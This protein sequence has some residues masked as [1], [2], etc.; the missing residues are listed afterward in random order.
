MEQEIFPSRAAAFN[1]H[2]GIFSLVHS[3][4]I[5]GFSAFSPH[6]ISGAFK[7]RLSHLEIKKIGLYYT[8][9]WGISK[10]PASELKN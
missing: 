7:T 6:A 8:A 10:T 2:I 9:R 1:G 3:P 5:R 4:F